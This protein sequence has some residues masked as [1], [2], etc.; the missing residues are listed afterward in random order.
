MTG[1]SY[2]ASQYTNTAFNVNGEIKVI[3]EAQNM[4]A[5]QNAPSVYYA[6]CASADARPCVF[7]DGAFY[8]G[9]MCLLGSADACN[10]NIK[11]ETHTNK[12]DTISGSSIVIP[13]Y[14]GDP[15]RTY[16]FV[17]ANWQGTGRSVSL[18]VN[19]EFDDPG[20]V[21]LQKR[22]KNVVKQGQF[23]PYEISATVNQDI[24]PYINKLKI[25]L[26]SL[27]GDADL[28]VGTEP[29]PTNENAKWKSRLVEP[30]DE[31]L[32]QDLGG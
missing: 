15:G 19:A 3:M 27:V 21:Q 32:I 25:T 14:A 23:L 11:Y 10:A 28:F 20:D 18:L 26:N 16:I 5:G 17:V 7:D 29:N 22:Y 24:Q 6:V 31:V 1:G 2:F 4:A 9:S 12:N 30:I 8:D 13:H